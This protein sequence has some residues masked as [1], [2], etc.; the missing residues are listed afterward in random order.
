[1]KKISVRVGDVFAVVLNE[2]SQKYFQ[3]IANDRTQLNSDVI[4]VFEE[5]Y[6]IADDIDLS[7]MV[8]GKV[9]FYAHV[10]IKW[11]IKMDLWD[12]VG[13]VK[14]VGPLDFYFRMTDDYGRKAGEE[15]V[16]I[17]HNWYIWKPNDPE[18][19]FVGT[20]KGEHRNA[21]WGVVVNPVS[22]VG[23]IRTGQYNM[24]MPGFE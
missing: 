10:M 20:L 3:Y 7:Q 22:I 4:R 21:H 24:A 15:P 14:E 16:R 18:F 6:P 2:T 12:K 9:E 23:R 19:T 5:A 13:N 8:K 17:S 11:G 1:M